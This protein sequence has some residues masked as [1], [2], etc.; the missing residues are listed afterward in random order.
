VI[1]NWPQALEHD[2]QYL[3]TLADDVRKLVKRG[4]PISQAAFAAQSEKG[5]WSLFENYNTR[6]ATAAYAELEWE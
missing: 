3:S 4:A 6:N 5:K 1:G 2:R